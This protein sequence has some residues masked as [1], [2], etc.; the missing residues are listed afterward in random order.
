MVIYGAVN[1]NTHT[2]THTRARARARALAHARTYTSILTIQ[3]LFY[4]AYKRAA[5]RDFRWLKTTARNIMFCVDILLQKS[6]LMMEH[7]N[8]SKERCL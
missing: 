7:K 4:T 3:S 5:N 1:N 2:H 6:T 8:G